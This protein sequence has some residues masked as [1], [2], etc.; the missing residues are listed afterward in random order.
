MVSLLPPVPPNSVNHHNSSEGSDGSPQ[1]VNF[2]IQITSV[3]VFKQEAH[4]S[5]QLDS[6]DVHQIKEHDFSEMK[7]PKQDD[8]PL[9]KKSNKSRANQKNALKKEKNAITAIKLKSV[10]ETILVH[11]KTDQDLETEK[12]DIEQLSKVQNFNHSTGNFL[13]LNQ[14]GKLLERPQVIDHGTDSTPLTQSAY[15]PL[16]IPVTL[17]QDMMDVEL[18]F[19]KLNMLLDSSDGQNITM[20]QDECFV[21]FYGCAASSGKGVKEERIKDIA[22]YLVK[23]DVVENGDAKFTKKRFLEFSTKLV[24]LAVDSGAV[25]KKKPDGTRDPTP[26]S[27]KEIEAFKEAFQ[28]TLLISL[29]AMKIVVDKGEEHGEVKPENPLPVS[30]LTV[31]RLEEKKDLS[32]TGRIIPISSSNKRFKA[33]E[34]L[35]IIMT[36]RALREKREDFELQRLDV[37]KD[38]IKLV[39]IERSSRREEIQKEDL[40]KI[41]KKK[42]SFKEIVSEIDGIYKH[43]LAEKKPAI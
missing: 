34:L 12:K 20:M 31:G 1:N 13:T 10:A 41:D 27:K 42:K 25:Y 18:L 9:I 35:K 16:A 17:K 30:Q 5:T 33:S 32:L 15:R 23:K 28:K 11:K 22:A 24:E 8:D 29:I 2:K 7:F 38:K 3:E 14:R 36:I 19:S 40:K 39:E 6:F 21:K 26:M 4:S 37:L 43:V